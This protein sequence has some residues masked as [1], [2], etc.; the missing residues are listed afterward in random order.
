M[1]QSA[2][3]TPELLVPGS[4]FVILMLQATPAVTQARW[5]VDTS[6]SLA[7]WQV[8]PNLNHLWATTCPADPSWRPGEGRS[9][10]WTMNI[11][12]RSTTGF[13]DTE[14]TVHVPLYPR[15]K[16]RH[17]CS[18]AVSG[19]VTGDTTHW[20]GIRGKFTVRADALATGEAMRD[21]LMRQVLE[22]VRYPNIAF[23]LDSV[24]AV[25]KQGD[26][27]TA[28]AVGTITVRSEQRALTAAIRIFPDSGNERVLAK[29]RIPATELHDFTP[30][31]QHLSLG[32]DT[33]VWKEFFMGVD[34]VLRPESSGSP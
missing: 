5:V 8:S 28:S 11:P 23:T 12:S 21:A 4:A 6:T 9:S 14:D 7:W 25:A 3:R 1:K 29:F 24:V 2:L 13:T 33:R 16:V 20:Q 30:G 17:L 10:G 19:E 27:V 22:T 15:R 18:E 32:M 34:L 26:T 31:L